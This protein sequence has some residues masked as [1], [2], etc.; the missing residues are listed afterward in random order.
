[1]TETYDLSRSDVQKGKKIELPIW[2]A[3]Q[4]GEFFM[5]DIPKQYRTKFQNILSADPEVVNLHKE[6][7][8][9]YSMGLKASFSTFKKYHFREIFWP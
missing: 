3:E 8:K 6:G 1:M 9:Y 7:P 4:L 5:H 2:L